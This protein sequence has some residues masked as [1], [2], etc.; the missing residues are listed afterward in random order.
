MN[1]WETRE[2]EFFIDNLLVQIHFIIF[3]KQTEILNP[4]TSRDPDLTN[5]INSSF[6][7]CQLW[8]EHVNF[9]S[10]STLSHTMY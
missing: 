6:Q 4:G 9:G 10:T 7:I 3:M 5:G 1:M 2:R 8:F